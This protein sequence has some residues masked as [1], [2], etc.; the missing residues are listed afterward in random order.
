MKQIRT[1]HDL[2]DLRDERRSVVCPALAMLEKPRPAAFVLNLSGEI[3]L[4]CIKSGMF[5]YE[6]KS[7][8][9]AHPRRNEA[10]H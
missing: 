3:I 7:N 8:D 5:L 10:K 9:P 2:H 6:K 4:R 1:L